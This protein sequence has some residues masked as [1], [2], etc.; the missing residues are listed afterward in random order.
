M[1]ESRVIAAEAEIDD[2]AE[3]S[4]RPQ[5][6]GDFVGQQQLRD[7]LAIFIAAVFDGGSRQWL[8]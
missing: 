4:L 8:R 2:G 5:T 3:V 7:N 6:L 1:S